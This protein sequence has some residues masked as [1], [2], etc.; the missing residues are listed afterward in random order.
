MSSILKWYS[1]SCSLFTSVELV[2]STLYSI[3]RLIFCTLKL[4]TWHKFTKRNSENISFDNIS[5]MTVHLYKLIRLSSYFAVP[6][7]AN[8]CTTHSI[9]STQCFQIALSNQSCIVWLMIR[10]PTHFQFSYSLTFP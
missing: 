2:G 1:R 6:S 4:L 9:L 10:V 8:E 7:G 5:Q 3:A